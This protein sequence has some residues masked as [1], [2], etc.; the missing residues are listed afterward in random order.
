MLFSLLTVFLGNLLV[1]LMSYIMISDSA[2]EFHSYSLS[3]SFSIFSL[4][5]TGVAFPLIE[6]LAFRLFLSQKEKHIAISTSIIYAYLFS[7]LTIL[8]FKDDIDNHFIAILIIGT[9]AF[10]KSRVFIQLPIRL[11]PSFLT[12]FTDWI[13]NNFKAAYFIS[14]IL[15]SL[16]HIAFQLIY[17]DVNPLIY[18]PV[19]F[20]YF[21]LGLVLNSLRIHK[22][23]WF[24]VIFHGGLNTLTLLI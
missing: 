4:I 8:I 17:L 7:F 21:I 15:F 14:A 19:F 12:I 23:F 10:I 16:I 2:I 6:E 24:A 11:G 9:F 20:S 3:I 22:G 18:F 1:R 13:H 5:I